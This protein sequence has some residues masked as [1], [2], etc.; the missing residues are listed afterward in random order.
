[1][2]KS[3]D[4]PDVVT[5]LLRAEDAVQKLANAI[6]EL[7]MFLIR[8]S[9]GT[10]ATEEIADKT[11]RVES[12]RT[13][14]AKMFGDDWIEMEPFERIDETMSKARVSGSQTLYVIGEH[15]VRPEE[16]ESYRGIL[17]SLLPVEKWRAGLIAKSRE[18][19]GSD[20]GPE[21]SGLTG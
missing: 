20:E 7:A 19:D 14:Y 15:N 16:R 6:G 8:N 2:S 18:G 21:D 9:D 10:V 17:E 11:T 12:G 3:D 5:V 1:M 4:A 13:V